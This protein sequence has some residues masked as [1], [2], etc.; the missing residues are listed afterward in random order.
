M[1]LN[2][3]NS[4]SFDEMIYNKGQ[5]CLVIFSR[6][7]CHVCQKVVPV[8]EELQQKYEGKFAFSY[9]D[10]EENTA[11]FQRFSLKGVPQILYFSEGE[12]R[13]KQTGLVDEELIEEKIATILEANP[14]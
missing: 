1:P 8:L 12:Y 7:T 3:L 14:L 10:S 5:A 9:V 4:T 6:K 13:G 2:Q 11:L